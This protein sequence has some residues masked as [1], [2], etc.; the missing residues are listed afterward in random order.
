MKWFAYYLGLALLLP[1]LH[2]CGTALVLGSA[3]LVG[4]GSTVIFNDRRAWEAQ[5]E[6]GNINTR[7]ENLFLANPQLADAKANIRVTC[8]N[9]IVLLTGQVSTLAL[10]ALATRLASEYQGVRQ[11]HNELLITS[12]NASAEENNQDLWLATKVTTALITHYGFDSSYID[13]TTQQGQ[14]YLMGLLTREEAGHVLET[15]RMVDGVKN[16]ISMFEYVRLVPES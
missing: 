12:Q 2:G 14:V 13:V 15:V 10:R 16:V 5:R 7:L 9:K 3:S 4:V 8:Y 6:D 1:A 11:V